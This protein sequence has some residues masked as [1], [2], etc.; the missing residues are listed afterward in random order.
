ME[1][2]LVCYMV[3]VI[4]CISTTTYYYQYLW[5]NMIYNLYIEYVL[6]LHIDVICFG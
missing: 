6:S 2:L 5:R 3:L 1:N 4:I